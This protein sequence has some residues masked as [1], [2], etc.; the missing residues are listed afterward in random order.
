MTVGSV[1]FAAEGRK[2]K[3]NDAKCAELSMCLDSSRERPRGVRVLKQ[4]GL[5]PSFPLTCPKS[6]DITA[7]Y[8]RLN[9]TLLGQM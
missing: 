1:A 7:D 8:K 5:Y 4:S 3:D 6:T 9:I 2:H